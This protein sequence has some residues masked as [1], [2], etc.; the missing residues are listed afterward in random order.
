MQR[1]VLQNIYT[2]I[3]ILLHTKIYLVYIYVYFLLFN[4]VI[5][6]LLYL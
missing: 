6:Y 2:F 1:F 4:H 5:K 3:Y